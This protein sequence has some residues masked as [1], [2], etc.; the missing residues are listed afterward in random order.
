MK[1][2]EEMSKDVLRRI[3]E[4]ETEKKLICKENRVKSNV[5]V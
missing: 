1:N 2:Y 4:Y 3:N 5:S